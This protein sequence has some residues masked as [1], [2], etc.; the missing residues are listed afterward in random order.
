MNQGVACSVLMGLHWKAG[1]ASGCDVWCADGFALKD[2]RHASGCGVQRVDVAS[3]EGC[4]YASGCSMLCADG[5]AE[6]SW[7]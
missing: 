1:Y 3:L 7:L 5:F 6:K 4:G 2:C